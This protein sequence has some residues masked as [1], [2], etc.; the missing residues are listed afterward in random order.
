MLGFSVFPLQLMVLVWPSFAEA[1]QTEDVAQLLDS[2]GRSF[3]A[4]RRGCDSWRA[5]HDPLHQRRIHQDPF[6]RVSCPS[7]GILNV[8]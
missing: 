5:P 1:F 2:D 4:C 7:E 6:V 8:S 3:G